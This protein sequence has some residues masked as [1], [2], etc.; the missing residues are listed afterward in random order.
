MGEHGVENWGRKAKEFCHAI[1]ENIP[2]SQILL[3]LVGIL[4]LNVDNTTSFDA[5]NGLETTD[6]SDAG[7]LGAPWRDIS[8]A[9]INID[10]FV[11][12]VGGGGIRRLLSSLENL[13]NAAENGTILSLKVNVVLP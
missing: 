6:Q 11:I 13:L 9:D 5:A 7:G 3:S 12:A 2:E 10:G 8:G 1:M 4:E